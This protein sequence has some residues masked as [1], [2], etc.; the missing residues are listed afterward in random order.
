MRFLKVSA[1]MA[2]MLF[3]A[4]AM[5]G[6]LSMRGLPARG[7]SIPG[8]TLN[9]DVNCDGRV[10][11]SDA[12]SVIQFAFYG[13][14]PPCAIAEDPTVLDKLDALGNQITALQSSLQG[15]APAWPPKAED[16]VNFTGVGNNNTENLAYVV[17]AG[18]VFVLTNL[19]AGTAPGTGQASTEIWE[20]AAGKRT[21]KW[22]KVAIPFVSS[23]GIR[24]ASGSEVHF[25]IADPT[26]GCAPAPCNDAVLYSYLGYLVDA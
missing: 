14:T 11:I 2:A 5:L 8:A 20:V 1:L 23:I 22:H 16:V 4:I 13:G 12:I 17:P 6:V 26:H 19:T 10:D 7:G 18:K 25:F 15:L 9:G 3:S 21:L 24:F